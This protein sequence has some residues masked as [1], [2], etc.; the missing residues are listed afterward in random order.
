MSGPRRGGSDTGHGG[1]RAVLPESRWRRLL[2]IGL[3]LALICAAVGLIYA[4]ITPGQS[5]AQFTELYLLNED[6][7]ASDYPTTLS[8]GE[9]AAILV[10]VQSHEA[11]T[12]SYRVEVVLDNRSVETYELR[13]RPGQ[14]IE[15]TVTFTPQTPGQSR[16]TVHLYRGGAADAY[17]S[18]YL[19]L[20]VQDKT[21]QPD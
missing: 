10:G 15:R 9:S 7:N 3:L 17:A 6:R 1:V 21:P 16:L 18:V 19:V 4:G 5:E 2:T 11:G 20:T 8:T 14:R 13:L 12:R